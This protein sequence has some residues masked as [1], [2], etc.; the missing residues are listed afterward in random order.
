MDFKL[1]SISEAG[2]AEANSKAEFY[3]VLNQPEEAESICRDVLAIKP[4]DQTALR[5][6]GLAITDQFTGGPSDRHIEVQFAFEQLSDPYEKLYYTGILQ[7]RRAKAQLRAG[8]SPHAVLVLFE[9]AMRC[10][11]EAEAIRPKGNDDAVLRWNSCV[12][13]LGSRK[14]SDWHREIE[15]F[16]AGDSKPM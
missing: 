9:E 15:A 5:T 6:L 12:R 14:D 1:K 13:L 10:Y 8:R 7:E 11:K 4:D 16:D 2:I 3:R